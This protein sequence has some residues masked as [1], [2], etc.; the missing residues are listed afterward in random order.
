MNLLRRYWEFCEEL[1][2]IYQLL[3]LMLISLVIMTG[4]MIVEIVTRNLGVCA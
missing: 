2:V 4:V 3:I 1:P